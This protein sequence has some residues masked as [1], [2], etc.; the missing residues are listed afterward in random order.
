[1]TRA[2]GRELLWVAVL[3]ACH[4][5]AS[6]ARAQRDG[7]GA[8]ADETSAP[9]ESGITAQL[10]AGAGVGLRD[11]SLTTAEGERRI[12]TG[13]FPALDVDLRGDAK[14]SD[15]ALLGARFRYQTS[16]GVVGTETPYGGVARE[17][18]LRS[19]HI[20]LGVAPALRFTRSPQGVALAAFLGWSLRAVRSVV[21]LTLPDYTLH[22]PCARLE[23]A[24]RSAP[25]AWCCAW[26]RS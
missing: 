23:L 14:L 24:R 20:E 8:A 15:H 3:L 10:G 21:H 25:S 22:G 6:T 16:L 19:H 18:S 4:A 11:V 13:L 7:A 9:A 12:S 26:P 5:L 2:A 1:M 17:T